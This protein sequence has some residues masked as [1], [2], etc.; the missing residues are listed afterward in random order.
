MNTAVTAI[1]TDDF[2]ATYSPEDNKLRLYATYRLDRDLYLRV[3][4]MGFKWAPKQGLF[5]APAWTPE[6]EDFCVELAGE[7]G[8]EGTTLAE[9]AE[10]K[11]ERLAKLADKRARQARGFYAAAE[12][13]SERF[14]FGQ[15]IL[16]GHHSERRARK[17]QERMHNALRN[18]IKA[19]EAVSYWNYR[20]R[21][22]ECHAEHLNSDR[23]R[24][25]RIKRLLADLR[26]Y[27]RRINHGHK[28]LR[29]WTQLSEQEAG[30]DLDE[31]VKRWASV[32]GNDGAF[33][34]WELWS[35]LDSGKVTTQEAIDES[36]AL[37]SGPAYRVHY[38]RWI[39]HIL[40]RLAY[41]IDML[42][43]VPRFEGTL[44]PVILQ[45]FARTQGANKPKATATDSGFVLVSDVPLPMQLVAG[46][47][48]CKRLELSID[49]WRELMHAVGHEVIETKRRA[50]TKSAQCPLINPTQADAEKL[51]SIWNAYAAKTK[52]GKPSEVRPMA[53][54]FY[55]ANSK[56][57]YGLLSTI[58]LDKRGRRIWARGGQD[59]PPAVCRVRVSAGGQL[60]S[61]NAVILIVDKPSKS[62]PFDLDALLS[63]AQADAPSAK[64]EEATP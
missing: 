20:V 21:G 64:E 26:T 27:Q 59:T 41:E 10:A 22:V 9:R 48:E 1:D 15:P 43:G 49:G 36:L 4:K 56:G 33:A 54:T 11:A 45:T 51:Q 58:S 39:Q 42:G 29:L 2:E 53:Q 38:P 14:A 55:S 8:P 7:I 52:Y 37:F 62:L 63:E 28:A 35:D 34:R 46:D 25:S 24:A 17:D 57:A 31:M 50:S 44:T 47:S 19:Q 6:R 16:V 3:K 12:A 40:N 60:Y 61:A 13:I 18:A 5:V 30:T 23:T 32:H